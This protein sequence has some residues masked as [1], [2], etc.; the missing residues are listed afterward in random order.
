[1]GDKANADAT[2]MGADFESNDVMLILVHLFAIET[3][4]AA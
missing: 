2:A 1:M 4:M 3:N